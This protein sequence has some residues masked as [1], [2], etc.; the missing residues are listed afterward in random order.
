MSWFRKNPS[1]EKKKND[2][3]VR[4]SF[5]KAVAGLRDCR[6]N[7][8]QEPNQFDNAYKFNN[9]EE[10]DKRK[11]AIKERMMEFA[12]SRD[13]DSIKAA[14]IQAV[15]SLTGLFEYCLATFERTVDGNKEFYLYSKKTGEAYPAHDND[16]K[17]SLTLIEESLTTKLNYDRKKMHKNNV[18]DA[19]NAIDIIREITG[20]K[21]LTERPGKGITNYKLSFIYPNK[22]GLHEGT[23]FN[24][25]EEITN[26]KE[27]IKDKIKE[28]AETEEEKAAVDALTGLFDHC[29]ATY[30]YNGKYYLYSKQTGTVY[31]NAKEEINL[32]IS[33]GLIKRSLEKIVKDE[34]NAHFFKTNSINV[35][36][37]KIAINVIEKAIGKEEIKLPPKKKIKLPPNESSDEDPTGGKSRRRRAKSSKR[38]KRSKA[39]KSGKKSSKR[40]TRKTRRNRRSKH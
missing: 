38:T 29:L 24:T 39:R 5:Q 9:S 36:N 6:V 37:A 7:G 4:S 15:N 1:D 26:R 11:N 35:N 40:S 14:Y 10:I 30:E 23:E 3:R 13:N 21:P 12:N 34:K 8:K 20:K 28:Y 18:N 22:K 33:L 2:Y 32:E 16:L 17:N 31:P 25:E 27:E 19:D